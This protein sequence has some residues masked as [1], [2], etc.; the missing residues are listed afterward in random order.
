MLKKTEGTHIRH[1]LIE[2]TSVRTKE[3]LRETE[4]LFWVFGFPLLLALALGFAF[5]SKPPD[6]IPAGVVEGPAAKQWMA[7]LSQS[8]A[9]LPR[10]YSEQEGR[11]ALRRGKISLLI[12]GNPAAP[13]YRYDATRPDARTARVEADDALQTAAGRRN[14]FTTQDVKVQEQGSRYIDFLVPGLLGMNLM[15]TGMWGMGFTIVNARMRKLLKR[16]VAT[17]MRK[18]HYLIAQFLSRLI[19]LVFEVSILVAFGWIVFHVRVNGSIALLAFLCLLGGFAFAGIGLLTASRAKTLEAVSGMMNLVMMPMW[20]CSGVFFSYE[21]FPD[22]VKPV[23]RALPLTAL[24]DAL[25]G[26]M[27]DAASFGTVLPQI[28]ILLAWGAVS[29]V[30]ALRIFRWQ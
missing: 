24:N 10:V 15:G 23:I 28:A 18:S 29:F 17:P 11:E 9:L 1:P 30:T 4:A 8:P 21:R 3:F 6:R 22:S 5:R 20:L 7:A 2:L 13:V 19:F 14:V 16:L 26:V 27:N 12:E 25:R